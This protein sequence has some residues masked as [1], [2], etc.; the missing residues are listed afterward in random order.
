LHTTKCDRLRPRIAIVIEQPDDVDLS[1]IVVRRER[2]LPNA[3]K[4][5]PRC[6]RC[7]STPAIYA[8]LASQVVDTLAAAAQAVTRTIKTLQPAPA[9]AARGVSLSGHRKAA[10]DEVSYII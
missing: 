9:A 8:A 4:Q 2:T 1:E 7:S 5:D 3:G 10:S 6:G